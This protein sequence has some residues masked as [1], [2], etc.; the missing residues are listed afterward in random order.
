MGHQNIVRLVKDQDIAPAT[1]SVSGATTLTG[2]VTL[3]G[4]TTVGSTLTPDATASILQKTNTATDDVTVTSTQLNGLLTLN[5]AGVIAVTLP[6]PVGRTGQWI[7]IASLTAQAHT[8]TAGA[9][10]IV[11]VADLAATTITAPG[12]IGDCV[13]LVSDGAKWVMTAMY[14]VWV[15]T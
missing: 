1:V 10:L 12:A 2:A 8:V 7:E 11:G 9:N 14:G 5:K 15:S 3:T 13:K 6:T 4:A